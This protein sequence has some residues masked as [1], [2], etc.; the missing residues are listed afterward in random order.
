MQRVDRVMAKALD[1]L[2]GDRRLDRIRRADAIKI[3]DRLLVDYRKAATAR[4]YL[5]PLK[6]LVKEA[7]WVGEHDKTVPNPFEGVTVEVSTNPLEERR[8]LSRDELSAIRERIRSSGSP[9]LFDIWTIL[10]CTG[11]RLSEVGGLAWRDV[12]LDGDPCPYVRLRWTDDRRLK[13]KVS[14]SDV[15]LSRPAFEAV[16]RARARAGDS[17][18]VLPA[19]ARDGGGEALSAALMRHVR[20]VTDDPLAVS[21]SPR[22]RKDVGYIFDSGR[23][24]RQSPPSTAPARANPV[25]FPRW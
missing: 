20:T 19:Y 14:S 11:C 2:G 8:P 1:V 17:P 18:H 6:A 25:G 21:H 22:Q 4:R 12:L 5:A 7:L 13:N 15:P 3:R 9:D 24:G 23:I 16:S 10:E